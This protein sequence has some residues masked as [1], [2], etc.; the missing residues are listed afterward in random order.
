V[1]ER[2]DAA[3]CTVERAA[4]HIETSS[5]VVISVSVGPVS[6][7]NGIP[8]TKGGEPATDEKSETSMN[9]EAEAEV[10]LRP[11]AKVGGSATTD[12]KLKLDMRVLNRKDQ[13][14]RVEG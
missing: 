2:L 12:V 11:E 4:N 8:L 5:A 7:E 6:V 1:Q 14:C 10:H 3:P 9:Y 13:F